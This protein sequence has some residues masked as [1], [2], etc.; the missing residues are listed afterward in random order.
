MFLSRHASHHR[1][2]LEGCDG[3]PRKDESNQKWQDLEALENSELKSA[4]FL[5]SQSLIYEEDTEF[6][7]HHC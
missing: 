4:L 6:A 7:R 1:Q 2:H 3:C 5:E